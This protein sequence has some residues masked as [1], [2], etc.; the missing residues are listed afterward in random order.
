MRT[1]L[2]WPALVAL[3]TVGCVTAVPIQTAADLSGEWKGRVTSPLGHAVA[4][5]TI[6]TDGAFKGTMYLDPGRSD[7]S[8][9]PARRASGPGALSGLRRQRRACGSR[10]TTDETVLRFLRDDGGWTRSSAVSEILSR[11]ASPARRAVA[12]VLVFAAFVAPIVAAIVV[13]DPTWIGGL[14]DGADGDEAA[15]LVW[16]HS[17]AVVP[18]SIALVGLIAAFVAARRGPSG[19]W[20]ACPV[21]RPRPA[22][23]PPL[24]PGSHPE[25]DDVEPTPAERGI[26]AVAFRRRRAMANGSTTRY[27]DAGVV[28]RMQWIPSGDG[29]LLGA[30]GAEG[31]A[32]VTAGAT[33]GPEHK[34]HRP[35]TRRR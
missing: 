23:R 11:H 13:P 2:R 26:G 21:A 3:L 25:I 18:A 27:G 20:A 35:V 10:T 12:L 4:T 16:D 19:Q 6:A 32:A 30:H 34:A 1:R 14:Y 17:S 31:R 28:Y 15:T 22:R 9:E 7:V 8:R 5:L 33:Q 24:T 29:G